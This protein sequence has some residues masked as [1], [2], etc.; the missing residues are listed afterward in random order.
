MGRGLDPKRFLWVPFDDAPMAPLDNT[1]VADNPDRKIFY[2]RERKLLD[3]YMTESDVKAMPTTLEAY[4]AKVVVPTL[5]RQKKAGAAAVKFEA[6]YLRS[7]DFGEPHDQEAARIYT[8]YASHGVPSKQENLIVQNAIFRAIA[9]QAGRIGLPVH[10]HT[11]TGCGGYFDLVGANPGLLNSVLSDSSFRNTTFV[12]IHGG[13]GPYT[14]VATFLM[15]KPNVYVDFS[16]QDALISTRAMAAVIR[17]WL[18]A[19]PEKVMFG[20]DLAPGSPE[21]GWEET[22]YSNAKTGREGLALAL[23]EMVNDGEI[24]KGRA[25]EIA[26]M[27]MRGTAVKLYGLKD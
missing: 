8:R 26:H 6:A 15:G 19:Y 23:S 13:S 9:H 25:L 22:G 10:I 17:D 20:T 14:K 27:V 24:T 4:I 7:L 18:E 2:A 1:T 16:E 5:E 3:K 12:L 21:I 11:G